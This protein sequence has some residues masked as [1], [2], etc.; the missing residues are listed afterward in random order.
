MF[1]F[2]VKSLEFL[3]IAHPEKFVRSLIII[4]TA[5]EK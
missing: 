3:F 1:N 5:P 4:L 2:W